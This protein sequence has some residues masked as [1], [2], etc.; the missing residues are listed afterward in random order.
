MLLGYLLVCSGRT[1]AR[2]SSVQST[3][4]S[5]WERVHRKGCHHG[6]AQIRIPLSACSR[7]VEFEFS[8]LVDLVS[9][10]QS[11]QCRHVVCE[12]VVVVK[13]PAQCRRHHV[14]SHFPND[15][16]GG[17]SCCCRHLRETLRDRHVH[18]GGKIH[19]GECDVNPHRMAFA[20]EAKVSGASGDLHRINN[21]QPHLAT[22]LVVELQKEG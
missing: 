2:S 1:V 7:G 4:Q 14:T 19:H 13:R 9:Q 12:D 11:S 18:D 21:P 3:Y 10:T 5:S 15:L 6:G 8:P 16:L 17:V 20:V 22:T